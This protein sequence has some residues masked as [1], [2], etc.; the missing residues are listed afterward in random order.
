MIENISNFKCMSTFLFTFI[1]SFSKSKNPIKI[2]K[3]M[4][5][6]AYKKQKGERKNI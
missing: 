4:E 3:M 5:G 1:R 2:L 6:K